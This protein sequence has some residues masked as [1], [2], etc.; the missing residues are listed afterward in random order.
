MQESQSRRHGS[1]A[2]S[3]WPQ[4]WWWSRCCW[5]HT[6]C[7]APCTDQHPWSADPAARR[8][9]RRASRRSSSPS[10]K[11]FIKY[12][13]SVSEKT[14]ILPCMSFSSSAQFPPRIE[15]D[16]RT[17]WR[18]SH[19]GTSSRSR[20]CP[21]SSQKSQFKSCFLKLRIPYFNK[22]KPLISY[23]YLTI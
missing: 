8:R 9:H 5:C 11:H 21:Q 15:S 14:K 22:L 17:P 13:D 7:T 1:D 2:I 12:H 20:T 3:G 23:S 10:V 19:R 16:P 6:W 18:R 4:S